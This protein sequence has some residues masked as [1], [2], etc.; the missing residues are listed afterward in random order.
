MVFSIDNVY[1]KWDDSLKGKDVIVADSL[2][3]LKQ[4]VKCGYT[5][6]KH[7]TWSDELL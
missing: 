7:V 2:Y 4:K 1:F 5:D 6:Y 3:S